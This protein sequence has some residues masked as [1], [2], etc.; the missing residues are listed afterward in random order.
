MASA[1]Y[2]SGALKRDD[3]ERLMALSNNPSSAFIVGGV[4]MGIY[5]DISIG[6]SL[7]ISV[8]LSVLICALLTRSKTC[9]NYFSNN[10][11]KQ[12]YDFISSVKT[13]GISCISIISF[14]SLFSAGIGI[15]KKRVKYTPLLYVFLA[16]SEVT[17]AIKYF[18]ISLLKYEIFL[19]ISS[20]AF[21]TRKQF[22]S[23]HNFLSY[24]FCMQS[25][26]LP[27]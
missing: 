9:K 12:N 15:I 5:G 16:F 3:A 7:L 18:N 6:F 26:M 2:T 20:Y 10:N 17:N 4:G 11:I 19:K 14:I 21:L 24:K 13:N 22:H 25:V 27:F 23:I 8:Y 1:Y